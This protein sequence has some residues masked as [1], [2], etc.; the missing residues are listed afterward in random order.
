[1]SNIFSINNGTRQGS[2]LSPALFAVYIDVLLKELRALGVG[3]GAVGFCDDILLIAPTRDGMQVMLNTCERFA[4]RNNLQFSTDPNPAKSKT[5]CIFMIGKKKNLPKPVPLILS[6]KE[7]P[8]VATATHLGHELH[9]S[10]SM[11]HDCH[12]KR[13]EFI[14]KSTDIRETFAFASPVEVL[15]AVKVFA[16]DLYGGNL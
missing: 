6:G 16:G 8:W 12:V 7:L 13:A 15:R 10:G 5:K 3:Y 4:L 9:E 11:D 2:I 14:S 1:M